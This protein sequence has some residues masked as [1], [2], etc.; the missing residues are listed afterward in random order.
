MRCWLIERRPLWPASPPPALTLRSPGGEVEFVLHDD[1]LLGRLDAVPAHE[2]ADGLARLVHERD[3]ER[4]HH[5]LV[6]EPALGDECVV[7]AALERDAPAFGEQRDGLLADVVAAAGVL[8]AGVAEADDE[9]VEGLCPCR[10]VRTDSWSNVQPSTIGTLALGVRAVRVSRRTIG[11]VGGSASPPSSP[12]SAASPSP[13]SPSAPSAASASSSSI[14]AH[15]QHGDDGGVGL[16][17]GLDAGRQREVL[18]ADDGVEREVGDVD[19]DRVGDLAGRR[20]HLAVP[21]WRGRR[22]RCWRAPPWPHP[23][24]RTAPTP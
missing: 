1:D 9:P 18:D 16:A 10:R 5:P 8:L 14:A 12:P 24:G 17:D 11:G 20:A 22:G 6:G 23:R 15:D 3:R 7:A 21:G 4:E 13:A 2:R 19:D